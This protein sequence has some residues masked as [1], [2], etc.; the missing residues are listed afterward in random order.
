MDGIVNNEAFR[1]TRQG[2]DM[3]DWT[4]LLHKLKI[5]TDMGERDQN[6]FLRRRFVTGAA[7]WLAGFHGSKENDKAKLG[8]TD[9]EWEI[10]WTQML[11]DGA[12][13]MPAL[14]DKNGKYLK[15]NLA[16][17]ML[18]KYIAHD[19]KA[20]IIVFD[21]VINC[22]QF[23]SGNHLKSNNVIFDSPLIIYATGGHFQA[24]FQNDHAYFIELSNKLESQN[25]S[26]SQ[27]NFQSSSSSEDTNSKS[28]KELTGKRAQKDYE[29][30]SNDEVRLNYIKKV[31]VKDRTKEMQREYER[32]MKKTSR[33]EKR[34]SQ[35]NVEASSSCLSEDRNSNS[36][37]NPPE[38]RIPKDNDFGNVDISRLANIKKVKVK[39][40]SKEMQRE[41]ERL[42]KKSTRDDKTLAHSNFETSSKSLS[43]DRSSNSAKDLSGGKTLEN[44]DFENDN[45]AKLNHI[46]K[47]K[48]KDRPKEMQREY[49]KLMK[50][51]TRNETSRSSEET[52]NKSFEEASTARKSHDWETRLKEIK[53][54]K[55][56]E[57]SQE[58]QR[59]Y[60]AL[61][62][63][64][65]RQNEEF[66]RKDHFKGIAINE[67]QDDFIEEDF[68]KKIFSTSVGSIWEEENKCPNCGAFRFKNERNFCCSKGKV[69]KVPV[70][71][72]P[73]AEM[74]EIFANE[75]FL[76]NARGYN[77]VLAMAS[78]GVKTPDEFKGPNFKI[79]GKVHHKIGSLI[80][81][82]EGSPKFLQLYFY[83][84]DE[85]TEH[86]LDIMPKLSE[87]I[88]KK[89]TS[90][91]KETNCYVKSFKAAYEMTNEEGELKIFLISDKSKIPSGQHSGR[92]NLPDG[93]EVAALMP[94][95][96]DG[97]LEVL[98][99]DR[100]NHLTQISTL[101][102]S[103][104]ALSY[105]LIDPYGTDG[106]HVGLGKKDGTSRNI[107]IAEF[108]S[109]RIQVRD[110]FNLLLRSRRCFQQYLV[111]QASKIENARMK[112]V[113]DN[114][115]TI[116][117]EKYNGLLD[118]SS[119]GDLAN[120]GVKIILPPTITGSPRF[121][122][123]KFQDAMAIARKFGKPTLFITM[124]CNPDWP[125]IK[126]ALNPGET[127]FDRPDITTRVFKLKNDMLLDYIEK[128]E[129][130]GKV[131]AYVGTQEQQKRKGLHHTHTLITLESV[132]RNPEDIDKMISAEIPDKDI[133]PEL[134]EIILKNNIHGP[135]GK[136]NPNSPCMDTDDRGRQFC[137]KEFPKDFQSSTCLTEFTYPKYKRRS[138]AESGRTAVKMVKGKPV[139]VD[140]S[141]VV[142]YNSFLSKFFNCHINV[143]FCET[144]VAIKYVYKYITKGP[145][146][147]LVATKIDDGT[148]KV[149]NVNE[150]EEF[151][152]ARYLG[153]S[154]AVL[155]I[156][157]FPIHYRSHNVEKLPCHLPGEQSVLFSEGGEEAALSAGPPE[158]KLTAF[159]KTNI[160]DNDAR[161][162]LYTDFP[163]HFTWK[164]GVW[165]RKKR[166]IGQSIGRIPTVSL[167]SKQMETYSL[168]ILLHHVPGP[169]SFD[170][171]KSVDGVLMGTFQEAC[172]KLGLLE[173]DS[174][175]QQALT[176]ACSIRFGD[177]LIS[178]FG[179]L[180]EF[181][182]PGS[183]LSLWEK[184][185]SELMHHIMH[186]STLTIDEA[187]SMVLEKLKEQL[188][189][190]GSDLKDFNL[191]EPKHTKKNRV[192]SLI[193][194]E[195]NFDYNEL[196]TR[197]DE[198]VAKMN[199]EQ[200]SFYDSVFSSVESQSGGLFGLNAAGGTGK[201]FIINTL[202]DKVRSQGNIALATAS[203]GVASKLLSNGTTV[204]SRFKVPIKIQ[205]TSTC[206]FKAT[207]A[208]GKLIKDT[209]LIIFDEM[210]M[211]HRH[212]FE[213]IDRSIRDLT[214]NEEPFGGITVVFSGDWRQCL[215]IV[216]RGSRGDVIYACMKSS[217]LW[218]QVTVTNLV[219]NMRV[220][221]TGDS[222]TFSNLLLDIGDGKLTENPNF[223]E[224]MV[225][226]PV[227]LFI[228]SSSPNELV[229]EVFKNF[230]ENNG[231]IDWV[232]GRAIL[233]PTNEECNEINKI[234]LE[235]MP[236]EK[237][238]YKSC[239]EVNHTEAHM[240]P[241]E[242]L[243]TIDLQGL[244]PHKLE[245]KSGA[246][247]ILLRNINPSEGHVNGTRYV[248]QN[249]L[250]HVI[251]AVAISG[252]KIGAK[253]FIPRIWLHSQDAILPFEMKRKQFP[254][255]LAYS[256]TANKAQGQTLDFV[257]IY[258]GKEFFSHGQFY[259]AISRVGDPS[260]V[261][262]L[263]KK[264]NS[265]HVRNIVYREIL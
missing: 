230:S 226:L 133:N 236:G 27:S 110:S 218:N 168:R 72:D 173:D 224:A 102:R 150:V 70:L 122:V 53:K 249:L 156:L 74:K 127:A 254:V 98:I 55:T 32:L 103:Y 13:A 138:P 79:Q 130:F 166:A 38:K 178:F 86:R 143:E 6:N 33:N 65:K 1:H 237:F 115:K 80:P 155:K 183:P 259:V 26:V 148:Q 219:R 248:I 30:E 71:K 56:K 113:L 256:M 208:T 207:D 36:A 43:Q 261:R 214:G 154:E 121:Y 84:T 35:S 67:N 162:L 142:P 81:A 46:K 244:P 135:C 140:N 76:R 185:K 252:S 177:Q 24:V 16:P 233:C 172:Q 57:R 132:P 61:M 64:Q 111:D 161:Q 95:D 85:A 245:L 194:T 253:I 96:G 265:Y 231:K 175:V 20:H 21:L 73:P 205:T 184:F 176:E 118:A 238:I 15:D 195:T 49:E 119:T 112:W 25:K 41:Y 126:D 34:L 262:I 54:I 196:L 134:F 14:T 51:F 31:K 225:Q 193:L 108:Y 145:D 131:I 206:S 210:T 105:V 147:C 180:L 151:V 66:R 171:L 153:A 137:S 257:G 83:D 116:K 201:T 139:V 44:D 232:R 221:L 12:W 23:C 48:V 52:Q 169:T 5:H 235:D 117:A 165:K 264:E 92:Y 124:T 204:H 240:Y 182:R 243:N 197:A 141:M 47:V 203:S 198:N 109:Y 104:D 17:K 50:K 75:T 163:G 107:S 191:P 99:R 11:E 63:R 125:E 170:D 69:D 123:E 18:I 7:E 186:N 179:S 213:A 192:P 199:P 62:K 263:Y 94:G 258:L 160:E 189:R 89:L 88:L 87:D 45:T 247:I 174:E 106:F 239:D 222:T 212:V 241:A 8:Y 260:S 10:M 187:E 211:L 42:M 82:D 58:L 250:P 97:E 215:P 217:E 246:V 216:R 9:Y 136:L 227:N 4:E 251:D 77:N 100:D 101:H 144:V 229:S 181:C 68:D 59:E 114:Q 167:C 152:D 190:S 159:F 29:F 242:F 149:E 40:R 128:K 255:R 3:D 164:S 22:I 37:K 39:D 202:L 2:N 129:I 188:N 158:T 200:R 19:L 78:V 209:K 93:C 146:R 228:K 28:A 220:E 91:I 60:D 90:I 157:R 234:L 120:A 223:G